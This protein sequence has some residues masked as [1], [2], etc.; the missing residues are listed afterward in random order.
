MRTWFGLLFAWTLL[1]AQTRSVAVI[2]HRGE[3]IRNVENT[4]PAFQTA[5]ELGADYYELDVRTTA[6]GKLILM[7]DETVDRTTNGRGRVSELT[8]GQIR[9]LR[10]GT[11][12]VPTFE[13]ALALARFRSGVYV[14][15]KNAAPR[16]IV[17]SLE[18]QKMLEKVVVYGPI[19]LLKQLQ[20]A[21]PVLRIMPESVNL[22]NM[23]RIVKELGPK[24]FAFGA[25]DW[26]NDLI[27]MA[28]EAGADLYVDRLGADDNPEK[29]QD[30]IDRGATGIQ[31][32][33]PGELVA[34]LRAKGLHR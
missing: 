5:I 33:R 1:A 10:A 16:D 12:Q 17:N 29:W 18:M 26:Q 9:S 15:V 19:N 25:Q 7:H 34:Y 2:A 31:T 32:D 13:E 30:A 14:D 4:L 24:V 11:A 22:A 3:H 8:F 27:D 6:D 23:R 20:T 28:K 21:R